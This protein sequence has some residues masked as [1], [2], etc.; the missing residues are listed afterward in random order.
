MYVIR[1]GNCGLGEV[2]FTQEQCVDYFKQMYTQ[3]TI[4]I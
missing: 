2:Y 3:V 4:Y 1:R